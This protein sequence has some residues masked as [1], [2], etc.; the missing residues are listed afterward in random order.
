MRKQ[1]KLLANFLGATKELTSEYAELAEI[2][3]NELNQISF[4]VVKRDDR[5]ATA[6][7]LAAKGLSTREIADITGWGH[8]VIAN[9]LRSSKSG[10]E[11]SKSGQPPVSPSSTTRAAKEERDAAV[12][13]AAEAEGVTPE[14]TKKYR[15]IYADPPWSY[16]TEAP[17]RAYYPVMKLSAICALPVKDWVEDNA[18]LFIWVTAPL[19][20]VRSWPLGES[21]AG[22]R[23]NSGGAAETRINCFRTSRISPEA[24][25]PLSC[26]G[27]AVLSNET[28]I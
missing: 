28:P 10:Q 9:D 18:V 27:P 14:P 11:S 23:G 24:W 19:L 3:E 17:P 2:T 22:W 20:P 6:K 12:A 5:K 4:T 15:I 8:S 21:L 7:A 1:A 16:N 26:Q 25:P 13:A